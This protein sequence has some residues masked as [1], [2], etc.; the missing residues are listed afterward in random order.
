MN[1]IDSEK[2]DSISIIELMEFSKW[3]YEKKHDQS[4]L[5]QGVE[6]EHIC[7][8]DFAFKEKEVLI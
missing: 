6:K 3:I 2:E 7:K 8:Y 4:L 1:F 5:N